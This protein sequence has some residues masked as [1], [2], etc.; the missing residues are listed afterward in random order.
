MCYH[1]ARGARFIGHCWGRRWRDATDN[2]LQTSIINGLGTFPVRRIC[3]TQKVQLLFFCS[4]RFRWGGGDS[5]TWGRGREAYSRTHT[6]TQKKKKQTNKTHAPSYKSSQST[7]PERKVDRR[8]FPLF[9]K[10]EPTPK[11][12]ETMAAYERTH[13]IIQTLS[14]RSV[15]TYS[16]APHCR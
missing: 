4:S 12:K 16:D 9:C 2:L 7:T 14:T 3:G 1:Q 5:C 15:C 8:Y 11:K 6:H 10:Q 13:I